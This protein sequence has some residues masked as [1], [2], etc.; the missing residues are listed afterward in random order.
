MP[1]ADYSDM[2]LHGIAGGF[3]A[4][5]SLFLLYPLDQLRTSLQVD[6]EHHPTLDV[7]SRLWKNGDLYRGLVAS[8]QTLGASYFVYFFFYQGLKS[9]RQRTKGGQLNTFDEMF[10][11]SVAGV[12]NVYLTSPLWVASMRLRKNVGKSLPSEVARIA[13]NEGIQALWAGV[14]PSLWLVSNPI[15]N[16]TVYDGLKRAFLNAQG[17]LTIGAGEAFVLGAIAKFV[18]TILTY[19]MQVVQSRLRAK[20]GIALSLGASKEIGTMQMLARIWKQDGRSGFFKGLDAKLAQTVLNAALM[21][22][23]Y[24]RLLEVVRKTL[25]VSLRV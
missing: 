23:F 19:P 12:I 18:A 9:R 10:A 13:Q 17:R 14:V 6:E 25:L 21:F 7:L 22:A 4:Q 24:E 5:G 1:L 15:I 8:L 3:A 11:S 2:A 16:F 20:E